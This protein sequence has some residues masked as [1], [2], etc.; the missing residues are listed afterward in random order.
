[1][2]LDVKTCGECPLLQD[3]MFEGYCTI[4]MR[5]TIEDSVFTIKRDR[6]H[7]PPPDNCPLRDAP[8]TVSLQP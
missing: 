7:L 5:D 2:N 1:M 3:T 4:L 6:L 8:I